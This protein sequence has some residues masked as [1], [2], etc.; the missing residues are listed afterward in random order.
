MLQFVFL[1]E[2]SIAESLSRVTNAMLKTTNCRLATTVDFHVEVESH[3]SNI[4]EDR[5]NLFYGHRTFA[6][7]NSWR[8]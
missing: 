5:Y 7:I 3:R 2:E 6:L 4:V 8:Y 1:A